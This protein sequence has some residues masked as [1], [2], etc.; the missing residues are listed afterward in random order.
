MFNIIWFAS[1]G[2]MYTTHPGR[3]GLSVGQ[4]DYLQRN[5]RI[6]MKLLPL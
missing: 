4:Q 2:V 5:E 1:I 3:V 6:C